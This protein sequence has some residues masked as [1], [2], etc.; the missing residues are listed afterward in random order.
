M[1]L[2]Q[3]CSAALS[4]LATFDCPFSS[5]SARISQLGNIEALP[6]ALLEQHIEVQQKKLEQQRKLL[7]GLQQATW[8][9][10][11]SRYLN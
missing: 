9:A 4:V 3:S 7:K 10:F 2:F 6:M 1:G 11:L 5:S 8:S